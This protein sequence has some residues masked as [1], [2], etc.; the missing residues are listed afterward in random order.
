MD[1]TQKTGYGLPGQTPEQ[2]LQTER[3][4]TARMK[5]AQPQL[6]QTRAPKPVV[7]K[8]LMKE[9]K[10]LMAADGLEDGF[11]F[12][13][14]QQAVFGKELEYIP[15]SIG[16]CVASSSMRNIGDRALAEI[17]LLDQPEILP[18]TVIVGKEN[19][20]TYGPFSYAAGR[21]V[22]G[23]TG[24][25]P[26]GMDDGSFV[27]A[28]VQGLMSYG[29]LLCSCPDL[30][31]AS[32]PEPKT[33][34]EGDAIYRQWGSDPTLLNQFKDSQHR[35][36]LQESDDVNSF[37][38]IREALMAFKPVSVGSALAVK[39]ESPIEGL[40]FNGKQAMMA[41]QDTTDSW[42]HAMGISGVWKYRGQWY[43]EVRNQ[44]DLFHQNYSQDF[45]I[46]P[47]EFINSWAKN[48]TFKTI[49]ELQMKAS[50][51]FAF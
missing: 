11:S 44:W 51:G 47:A 40:S 33:N 22:G 41:Y 7:N 27:A 38:K 15:Q 1:F 16:S 50:E 31:A 21:T 45:F 9:V 20:L 12:R 46:L 17:T 35:I 13:Y 43:G 19:L 37:D 36:F 4:A 14:L 28:H 34:R 25:R 3:D 30:Q 49:G 5:A 6:C 24:G 18:G 26:N 42:Q 39:Q 32:Y 29:A 8:V 23:I 48:G 10:D 2:I